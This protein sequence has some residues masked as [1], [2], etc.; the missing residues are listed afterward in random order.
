MEKQIL[1]AG[2]GGQ[3]ALSIG[4]FI[5]HS[6]LIEGHNVSYVPSYGAEMRGGTANC[7]VTISDEEIYSPLTDHPQQVIVLNRPSL[8]K[9]ESKIQPGGLLVIN[10]SLVDRDAERTDIE[11]L[12]I[13]LNELVEE[14][15]MTRGGN[16]IM[17]GAFIKKTGV[18]P[19]DIA[20]KCFDVV[21]KG[22][23]SSIEKN[24]IAFQ[25]GIDYA[26]NNWI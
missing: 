25:V 24:R 13:P 18:I 23:K 4:L 22:K 20:I 1:V 21:F 17:L 16:M 11:V 3:G 26:K 2:F 14:M 12:K 5:A 10:T 8:D 19:I 9:F 7:L 6:A 15:G